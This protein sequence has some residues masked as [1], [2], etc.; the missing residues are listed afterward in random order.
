METEERTET[1]GACPPRATPS[2]EERERTTGAQEETWRRLVRENG[3]T[4]K[5]FQYEVNYPPGEG[6]NHILPMWVCTDLSDLHP[7]CS[8]L[9]L[10]W[11][12]SG[13]LVKVP[14]YRE[15]PGPEIL[16]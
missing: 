3:E 2:S 10:M 12:L 7:K 13:R 11:S 1:P 16:T 4:P 14:R 6:D 8:T 15:T 5:L 9:K